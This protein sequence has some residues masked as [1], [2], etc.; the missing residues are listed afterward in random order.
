MVNFFAN[1]LKQKSYMVVAIVVINSYRKL[2]L[3]HKIKKYFHFALHLTI[4]ICIYICVQKYLDSI[5]ESLCMTLYKW[6]INHLLF[7][8]NLLNI[9]PFAFANLL[10]I[11]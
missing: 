8:K 11:L 3:V 1:V 5:N 2:A 9:S 10:G 6:M 4:F 7:K